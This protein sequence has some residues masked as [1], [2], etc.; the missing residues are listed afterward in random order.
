MLVSQLVEIF[1]F[2]F[3]IY[4]LVQEAPQ[5]LAQ[6]GTIDVAMGGLSILAVLVTIVFVVWKKSVEE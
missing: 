2:L 1:S 3:L 6:S 4:L 5:A